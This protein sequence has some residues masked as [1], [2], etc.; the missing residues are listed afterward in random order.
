LIRDLA[1][2]DARVDIVLEYDPEDVNIKLVRRKG[3]VDIV[4]VK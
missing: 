1:V 2:K 4:V 3:E